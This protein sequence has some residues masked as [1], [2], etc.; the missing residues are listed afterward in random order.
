[1]ISPYVVRKIGL[2][3]ARELCLTGERFGAAR[4]NEI[5]LVHKVGAGRRSRRCG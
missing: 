4:A 2:S 3:A 1:M 5:G